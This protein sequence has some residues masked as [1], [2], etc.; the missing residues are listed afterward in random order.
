MAH[1]IQPYR[2]PANYGAVMAQ[3]IQ[4]TGKLSDGTWD[5][6][7]QGTNEL[8]AVLAQGIQGTGK[9]SDG[10]WDTAIQGTS[11]LRWSEPP[12]IMVNV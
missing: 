11:E 6:A 10:T 5:T 4:G 2:E 3:G 9:L 1:G 12:V 7:I 8:R